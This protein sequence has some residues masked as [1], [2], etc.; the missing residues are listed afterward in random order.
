MKSK[1]AEDN[2]ITAAILI[3]VAVVAIVGFQTWSSNFNSG[4]FIDIEESS[5]YISLKIDGVSSNAVFVKASDNIEINSI[6]ISH[7]NGTNI[8][9]F[10]EG[11]IAKVNADTRLLLSFDNSFR[12]SSHVFDGS[13]Y[14]NDGVIF[15]DT[16]CSVQGISGEGCYFDGNQDHIDVPFDQS[17]NAS[18]GV[19]V[20]FWGNYTYGDGWQRAINH[21]NCW[22]CRTWVLITQQAG[23]LVNFQFWGR[24]ESLYPGMHGTPT[25]YNNNTWYHVVGTYDGSRLYIY[26][27]GEYIANAY[28]GT[29][30]STLK[31]GMIDN[32]PMVRIGGNNYNGGDNWYRG[33][34]DEV[35]IYGRALTPQEVKRIYNSGRAVPIEIFNE[36]IS[37]LNFDNCSLVPGQKYSLLITTSQHVIDTDFFKK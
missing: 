2:I 25:I 31:G 1:N 27:N 6:V 9:S 34:I 14:G 15:D 36:G 5:E 7:S 20:S 8:C 23:G 10:A 4:I 26:V 30:N 37:T 22:N 21:A 32:G 12:N 11:S 29:Y 17:L 19:S 3:V 13:K 33:I 24:N 28:E 16:D 35:S 18:E